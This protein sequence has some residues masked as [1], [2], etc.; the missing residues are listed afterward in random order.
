MDLGGNPLLGND[1]VEV[2]AP[3]LSDA[4]VQLAVNDCNIG[5]AG[6]V[7]LAAVLPSKSSLRKLDV[8]YSPAVSP[9]GW[10]SLGDAVGRMPHLEELYCSECSGMGCEGV[11]SLVRTL[12]VCTAAGG[13]QLSQLDLSKCEIKDEGAKML[14]SM[15]GRCLEEV[16][17]SIFILLWPNAT[18]FEGDA[19]VGVE[20]RPQNR[21]VSCER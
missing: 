14:A 19:G 10:A 7:A 2:L 5:D 16:C 15:L 9:K 1:G 6:M 11:A 18:C 20:C 17:R 8:G 13:S 4:L 12:P 3:A 21:T